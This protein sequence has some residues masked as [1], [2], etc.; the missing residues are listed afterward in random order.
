MANERTRTFCF[1]MYPDSMPNNAID[2]LLSE[3]C[4][5][6]VSPIHSPEPNGEEEERKQHYHVSIKF[7][8]PK[9]FEKVN[10]YFRSKYHGTY[11]KKEDDHK[12]YVRYLAHLDQP[13]KEKL[14]AYEIRSNYDIR[15][16]IGTE[17]F[18]QDIVELIEDNDIRNMRE[19]MRYADYNQMEKIAK[20]SY[21]IKEYIACRNG[22]IEQK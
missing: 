9:S 16:Y 12:A 4:A 13:E 14:N 5:I 10:E 8:G 1:I 7:S 17:V 11:L 6:A 22:Q 2:M 15:K 19:L 18:I 3:H 21:F 20:V